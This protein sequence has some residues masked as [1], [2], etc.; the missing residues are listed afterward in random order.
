VKISRIAHTECPSCL[1]TG[2]LPFF[3]SDD[4]KAECPT[5][6]RLLTPHDRRT[7]VTDANRRFS[8]ERA[9]SIAQGFHPGEVN[10]A[11]KHMPKS[12]DLIKSD[13]RVIFKDSKSEQ[14]F[15]KELAQA[16]QTL[17]AKQ[18]AVGM[19]EYLAT[20]KDRR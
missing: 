15:R 3:A 11:R 7:T 14:T 10:I 4:W 2:E 8:G 20:R 18:D 19:R 6:G 17:D 16:R 9:V 13:G 1:F 5:C 12:A